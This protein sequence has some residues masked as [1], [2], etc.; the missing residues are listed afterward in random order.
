ML[1]IRKLVLTGIFL[2]AAGWGGLAVLVY[3]LPPTLGPRWLLYFLLTVG[4]SGTA[5]PVVALLNLRFP[6]EPPATG[7]TALRQSLWLGIYGSLL[8]WLQIGRVLNLAL[9]AFLAAG[10]FL[11]EFLLRLRER[12]RW[13]PPNIADE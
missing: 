13:N 7:T 8:L 4:L 6:T 2:A 10:F 3:Y 9:A 12:S 11:I 1:P 5:L